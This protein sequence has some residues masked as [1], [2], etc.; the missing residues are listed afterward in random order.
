MWEMVYWPPVPPWLW[1]EAD[2]DLS[3]KELLEKGEIGDLA[4]HVDRHLK[5]RWSNYIDI[6]TAGSRDPESN[7]GGF[8]SYIP[9]FKSELKTIRW[10]FN[11]HCR[12]NC[13][14][15]GAVVSGKWRLA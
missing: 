14:I 11:I 5:N 4:A 8:G 15:V 3:I 6:Y 1:A 9:R 2:V 10:D 12:V 7:R 13:F